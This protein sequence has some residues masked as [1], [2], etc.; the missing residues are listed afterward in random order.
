MS[1]QAISTVIA[2]QTKQWVKPIS[3]E[4]KG[5]I[6]QSNRDRDLQFKPLKIYKWE[7]S[8][9]DQNQRWQNFFRDNSLAHFVE[10]FEREMANVIDYLD[11][12]RH[13]I[14][15]TIKMPTQKQAN[16]INRQFLQRYQ[17]IP[18]LALKIVRKIE[19]KFEK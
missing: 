5:E 2:L 6:S 16:E 18:K 9:E 1:Q 17:L 7:R 11:L 10:S 13:L 3:G 4:E 19:S 12:D 14:A 15:D 8:F